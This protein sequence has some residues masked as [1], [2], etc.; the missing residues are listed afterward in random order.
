MPDWREQIIREI[1]PKVSRLTVVADPDGI[2]LEPGILSRIQELG[3]HI[4][5]FEDHVAFRFEYESKYRVKWDRANVSDV[6]VVLRVSAGDLNALPYDLLCGSRKLSFSLGDIFPNLSYGVITALDRSDFDLLYEAIRQ[7][8]PGSMGENASK[9]FVLR[10]VFEIAPEL[11][12]QSADLLRCLLRRHYREQ[13]IPSLLDRRL[14]EVL[15]HSGKFNDWPLDSIVSDRS[16]FLAFLQERWPLFLDR[17]AKTASDVGPQTRTDL[18]TPGPAALPFEH[19]D[20]RVYVDNFFAEGLLHPV[21][22]PNADAMKN[23]WVAVGVIIDSG[24]DACHRFDKLAVSVRDTLPTDD[25]RHHD[26]LRFSRRWAELSVLANDSAVALASAQREQFSDLRKVIDDSFEKW[27]CRQYPS[28]HNQPPSPPVMVHHVPRFLARQIEDKG[29]QKI[30]LL[31][32]DG[33]SLEQWVVIR[34]SVNFEKAGFRCNEGAAFAWVPTITS[35][36]RQAI[37]SG[38]PPLFFPNSIHSTD[39]EETLWTQFWTEQGFGTPHILYR[40]GSDAANINLV[41]EAITTSTRICGLVI[42]KV[43]RIMHGMELGA[44]GMINQVRQWA[45]KNDFLD[46]LKLLRDHGFHIF[47]TSDHGNVESK[48][49]GNPSEGAVADLHGQRARVYPN[50]G[51]RARVKN[52]FPEA[53]AWS[54]VGLP[55]NY[56]PLLAPRRKAF[57]RVGETMVAHGG[58]SIE[59][60]IVPFV[61]LEAVKS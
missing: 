12:K 25:S 26:W 2:L 15:R 29:V 51:L 34:E 20:V 33:L 59:E 40:R 22:H 6:M 21:S 8:N 36:S 45:Q 52:Q 4:V 7:Q 39:K 35:V 19:D 48:G 55:E 1:E 31:V 56:L 60:V 50:Q 42:D 9:D 24:F 57:I 46:I 11:I 37:F 53:I 3:F 41:S 44:S 10:H 30:A 38:K 32:L 5:T 13:R 58:I 27:L 17:I 47:L 14:I 16:A 54:P 28:L 18:A 23:Q 43:D 49:F 61:E